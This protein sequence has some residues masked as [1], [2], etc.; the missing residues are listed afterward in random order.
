MRRFLR[1]WLGRELAVIVVI[2]LAA[3][4][5]LWAVFFSGATVPD[6]D[7]VA[8]ALV[9]GPDSVAAGREGR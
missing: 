1:T 9:A 4:A 2:K 5:A 8:R 3:L 7:A 6:A